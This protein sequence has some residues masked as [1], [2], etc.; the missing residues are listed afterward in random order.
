MRD[1]MRSYET[2]KLTPGAEARA[3]LEAAVVRVGPDMVADERAAWEAAALGVVAAEEED[4]TT[5]VAA[6][7]E[8]TTALAAAEEEDTTALAAA[9][10]E[11]IT[12]PLGAA[13]QEVIPSMDPQQVADVSAPTS[14]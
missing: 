4:T 2:L 3:V 8:D 9:V 1:I 13:E 7:E 14:T 11:N 10:Q 12:T 6:E 5:L